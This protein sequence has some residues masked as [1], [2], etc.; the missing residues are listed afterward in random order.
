MNDIK[1]NNKLSIHLTRRVL[2][3]KIQKVSMHVNTVLFFHL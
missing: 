1:E 3:N 2:R